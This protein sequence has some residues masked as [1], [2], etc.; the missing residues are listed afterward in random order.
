M[1][2][3]SVYKYLNMNLRRFR[4]SYEPVCTIKQNINQLVSPMDLLDPDKTLYVSRCYY[5]EPP[6]WTL[7]TFGNGGDKYETR[8][9]LFGSYTIHSCYKR[10]IHNHNYV[11]LSIKDQM[12]KDAIKKDIMQFVKGRKYIVA[13]SI[14]LDELYAYLKIHYEHV[15]DL[16]FVETP[17]IGYI[18]ISHKCVEKANHNSITCSVCVYDSICKIVKN[19]VI[20]KN[21]SQE[22]TGQ[23]EAYDRRSS[24]TTNY[25]SIPTIEQQQ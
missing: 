9:C 8:H 15:N 24:R 13:H 1:E 10:L 2:I 11:T 12:P 14:L 4:R 17:D 16:V 25:Q 3:R 23:E 18:Y 20:E 7:V 19:V 6:N 5:Y 21:N 22:S